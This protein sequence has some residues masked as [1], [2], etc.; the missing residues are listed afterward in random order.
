MQLKPQPKQVEFFSGN[1]FTILVYTTEF[2][3]MKSCMV[4]LVVTIMNFCVNC[5]KWI[6]LT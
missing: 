6:T 5:L 4:M 1:E 2:M 3:S